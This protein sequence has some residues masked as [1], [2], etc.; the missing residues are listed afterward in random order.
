RLLGA[1]LAAGQVDAAQQ[2]A[3]QI[4]HKHQDVAG[5]EAAI[6]RL[7][8][9]HQPEAGVPML[10]AAV[11]RQPH[12]SALRLMLAQSLATRGEVDQA[13]ERVSAVLT[14]DPTNTE[15][16]VLAWRLNRIAG[17]LDAA[18]MHLGQI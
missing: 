18:A 15:A 3:A 6:A 4:R 17:N 9:R 12:D 10:E 11:A 5:L 1:L 16:H 2:L 7:Y 8:L 14:A 13:L